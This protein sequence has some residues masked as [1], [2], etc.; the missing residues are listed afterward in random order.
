MKKEVQLSICISTFNRASFLGETLESILPQITETVE[1]VIVD[2]GSSDG[3][4][5]VVR[6][7]LDRCPRFRYHKQVENKGVDRDFNEAV[8]LA[9]GTY[10]WLFTDDDLM[11]PGA[12]Q[13]V[14]SRLLSNP[15]LLVVNSEIR[16]RDFSRILQEKALPFHEDRS[17][18]AAEWS[19][20][21]LE[22]A[23]Y[24]SFIGGIVIRKDIWDRRKKEPYFGTEFIHVGVI[25]QEP[26]HGDIEVLADPLIMIRY[27]N[28]Q[29]TARGFEIWMFK[30]PRLIWSFRDF[31][32]SEKE[33]I[34]R[35]EPWRSMKELIT[36]RA[37]GCYSFSEYKKWLA[38]R[39][40]TGNKKVASM[41]I[42]LLPGALLNPICYMYFTKKYK[43]AGT[44]HI[45]LMNSRFF[46]KNIFRSFNNILPWRKK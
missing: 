39:L 2:G 46:Y 36:L 33:K 6:N 19:R 11:K 10:C 12:V 34:I 40:S 24:C 42:S 23:G 28:A 30:W 26:I 8:S 4:E 43:D 18:S 16:N 29:W 5:S 13:A 20:F 37:K 17:Y 31:T 1:V 21:F 44:L 3:T 45:D 25:F 32:R 7:Y 35:E 15:G 27:G 9:T 41:S 14:L 38:P 22:V